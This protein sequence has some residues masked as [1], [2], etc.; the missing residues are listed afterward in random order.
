MC[1]LGLTDVRGE[2]LDLG[3]EAVQLVSLG[4]ELALSND[5]PGQGAGSKGKDCEE[6]GLHFERMETWIWLR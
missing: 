3:E 2:A 5:G 6:D 4:F 1:G